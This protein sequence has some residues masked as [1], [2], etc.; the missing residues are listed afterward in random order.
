MGTLYSARAR[1]E[2][3]RPAPRTPAW[4]VPRQVGS[5]HLHLAPSDAQQHSG[6]LTSRVLPV[7]GTVSL[8]FL[9]LT[10]DSF[11]PSAY[12]V[13]FRAHVTACRDYYYEQPL[14]RDDLHA[15]GVTGAWISLS[16]LYDGGCL[17]LRW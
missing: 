14:L 16:M 1:G 5:L 12:S 15:A 13:A 6:R 3:Y 11:F 10:F 7:L 2:R 8:R 9:H 4:A 17:L